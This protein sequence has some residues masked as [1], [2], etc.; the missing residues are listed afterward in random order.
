MLIDLS[1]PRVQ[2]LQVGTI[3]PSLLHCLA[4]GVAKCDLQAYLGEQIK[5][6]VGD[7]AP[8]VIKESL[9][10]HKPAQ[11]LPLTVQSCPSQNSSPE[12]FL[13]HN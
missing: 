10:I 4:L 8:P 2:G 3:I 11:L 7:R 13:R 6:G 12:S 9:N 1:P 5:L